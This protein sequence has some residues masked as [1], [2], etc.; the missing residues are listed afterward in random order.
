MTKRSHLQAIVLSFLLVSCAGLPAGAGPGEP[1]FLVTTKNRDE[2]VDIRHENGAAF[3]DI[4][5]PTGIGSAKF[6]L[7]SGAMPGEIVV[8]LHLKGLEEVRLVSAEDSLSASVS[9]S[10]SSRLNQKIISP[11]SEM[12]LL[13]GHPLWMEIEI[14]SG[15]PEKKIPL[16][17]GYFEIRLPKEFIR[18]AGRSFE[19]AW[20]DFYR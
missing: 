7:E 20:I 17:E 8:R 16:E 19:I 12:P 3:I 4:H 10:D 11:G 9:S 2:Q 15:Q 6:E 18:K 5:S 1:V 14:V 13:P